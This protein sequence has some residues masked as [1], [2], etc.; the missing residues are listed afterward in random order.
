MLKA[1]PKS[2]NFGLYNESE[3]TGLTNLTSEINSSLNT[4]KENHIAQDF[5]SL[6]GGIAHS[7]EADCGTMD[8]GFNNARVTAKSNCNNSALVLSRSP[9]WF[10][11]RGLT[12]P[13]M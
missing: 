11:G 5:P 13:P 3:E 9:H 4:I 2:L 7:W 8:P 12:M 10:G 1:P 6:I